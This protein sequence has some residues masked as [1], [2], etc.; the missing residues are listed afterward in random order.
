VMNEQA[1]AILL[2]GTSS[3]LSQIT[4]RNITNTKVPA[5]GCVRRSP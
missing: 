3:M 2:N 5:V 4:V 1:I